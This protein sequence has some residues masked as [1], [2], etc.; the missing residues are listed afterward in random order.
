MPWRRRRIDTSEDHAEARK[1]LHKAR[2][3]L[4]ITEERNEEIVS[5]AEEVR[6][7]G[8]RNSFTEMIEK[9]LHRP[10]IT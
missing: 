7:Y 6:Q 1:A 8:V 3:D 10:R 5:V 9:A 2:K 4:K